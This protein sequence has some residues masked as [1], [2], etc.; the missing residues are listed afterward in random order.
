MAVAV[1]G[2]EIPISRATFTMIGIIDRR[3]SATRVPSKDV[4]MVDNDIAPLLLPSAAAAAVKF[5]DSL[6]AEL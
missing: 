2:F 3:T 1:K 4:A 6:K 5:A